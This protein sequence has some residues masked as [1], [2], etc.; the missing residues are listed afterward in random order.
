MP[1]LALSRSE[2]PSLAAVLLTGEHRRVAGARRGSPARIGRVHRVGGR[3][4][5]TPPRRARRDGHQ[6]AAGVVE[7]VED[8]DRLARQRGEGAR[9]CDGEATSRARV[10]PGAT[11]PQLPAVTPLPESRSVGEVRAVHRRLDSTS[12]GRAGGAGVG[13]VV[14]EGRCPTWTLPR[15]R[16]GV[17]PLPLAM[18]APVRPWLAS[19]AAMIRLP[20]PVMRRSRAD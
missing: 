11:G 13:D 20:A 1:K 19:P 16:V 3:R 18:P 4:G 7:V 15:V 10:A 2:K 8:V 5:D 14:G 12:Q 17:V 6:L 9:R